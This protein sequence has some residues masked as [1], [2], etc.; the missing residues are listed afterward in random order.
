MYKKIVKLIIVLMCMITIFSFSSDNNQESDKKSDGVI[1]NI[2]SVLLGHKLSEKEKSDYTSRYVVLVRKGAHYIIY[3]ILGTSL[4]SFIKEYRQIDL[5]AL[6][7]ALLIAV[8]YACS[9]EIHQ[10]F[11]KGRSGEITDILLDGVGSFTGIYIYYIINKI[12]S[13]KYEQK[14]AIS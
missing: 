5:K 9:D 3:M 2:T 8:L 14:K 13:K 10:L 11:V 6:L 1:I 4:I 12:R 7:I